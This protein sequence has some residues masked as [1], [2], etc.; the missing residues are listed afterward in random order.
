MGSNTTLVNAALLG[1][2]L[3]GG[4][5]YLGVHKE[6]I[7]ALNVFPVPDGDTGINMYL[8]VSSA[9]NKISEESMANG[10]GKVAGDFAFGALMGARG[11][12]GV[13]L[14]QM[15]RGF[16]LALAG[17]TEC[18]AEDLAEAMKKGVDLSYKSIMKPVEGTILTVFRELTAAAQA[19]A[20][21]GAGLHEMIESAIEAGDKA[22]E[23]TPNQLPVLKEAGVVDAGG[24]GLLSFMRGGLMATES[25]EHKIADFQTRSSSLPDSSMTVEPGPAFSMDEISTANIEFVYC[26]QL[27][28][29]GENM[30]IDEIRDHLSQD[31]PGDS[32]L[33]VGDESIIK[34]HFHN[35]HPGQVLE[36]CSR[37]GTLH[38]IIIDNMVDQHHET[39]AAQNAS[40]QKPLNGQSTTEALP[41]D[42]PCGVVAVCA[43]E[44]MDTIF[45]E[46]GAAVISG[47]QTM[48][49]S[50][51]DILTAVEN[52]P[53]AEIV[54]L[55]NNSNIFLAADQ[56]KSLTKK[57]IAV[58]HSKFVTQGLTAMLEFDPEKDAKTNSANMSR[59]LEHVINGEITYAIRPAKYNGFN[60]KEG[61][62][63]ALMD[64]EIIANGKSLDKM[65]TK[66][67]KKMVESADGSEIISLYRGQ[68]IEEGEAQVLADVLA[69][70]FPDHEVELY[71]GGQPL[72]Y[73][74][75]SVE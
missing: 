42:A 1:K 22:L 44:G 65:L 69:D 35:N 62:I 50:A 16:S 9:A 27:L 47:G 4:S 6:E 40:G 34:I 52:L 51:E 11:N 64:G 43:G 36:Y 12:S 13:I 20:A 18:T 2:F 24:A 10:V 26:T 45:T 55:P 32:L 21:K 61:D 67:V 59:A 33:V 17:K 23:N 19:A 5:E 29:K 56:V 58:I 66:L 14:S 71:Y 37:F 15:F 53:A 48:N 8:T 63:L 30:P 75:L 3:Q 72:Y 57:K 54:I 38:D 49:P 73:F 68:D 25:G 74:L 39:I 70:K 31:P 7:N 28:I 60:I 46:L 41:L